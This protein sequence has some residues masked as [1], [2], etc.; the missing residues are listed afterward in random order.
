[1]KR[2]FYIENFDEELGP[3]NNHKDTDALTENSK[4]KSESSEISQDNQMEENDELIEKFGNLEIS[5]ERNK[6]CTVCQT[7]MDADTYIRKRLLAG[8]GLCESEKQMTNEELKKYRD[9]HF[10]FRNKVWQTSRDVDMV[11]KIN[12]MYLSGNEEL[13]RSHRGVKIGDL[14]DGL[15]KNESKLMDDGCQMM[16]GNDKS[17]QRLMKEEGTHVQGHNGSMYSDAKW[18][19]NNEKTMNGGKFYGDIHPFTGTC[20]LQQTV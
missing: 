20:N 18:E 15:T 11:D 5:K 8:R 4:E 13:S 16:S 2:N 3:K 6:N 19:Y 12:D 14:F 1:M 7:D 17:I 9:K 10:A